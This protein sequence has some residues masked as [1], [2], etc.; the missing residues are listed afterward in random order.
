[1]AA[2]RTELARDCSNPS[3]LEFPAVFVAAEFSHIH[4]L[5]DYSCI[6]VQPKIFFTD[7]HELAQTIDFLSQ[8]VLFDF[9]TDPELDC[10]P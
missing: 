7:F 4:S 6:C 2:P 3:A 8:Q 10:H 1:V 9:G 5:F